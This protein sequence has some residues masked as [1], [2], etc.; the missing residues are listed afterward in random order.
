MPTRQGDHEAQHHG[1]TQKKDFKDA[2]TFFVWRVRRFLGR[3]RERE[4]KKK[5]K[6][7]KKVR[8]HVGFY[9]KATWLNLPRGQMDQHQPHKRRKENTSQRVNVHPQGDRPWLWKKGTKDLAAALWSKSPFF[10]SF[11]SFLSFLF[12]FD[13]MRRVPF[14][15]H[16]TQSAFLNKKWHPLLPLGQ[17]LKL[18]LKLH[19]LEIQKTRGQFSIQVLWHICGER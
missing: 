14:S 15:L 3:R 7:E 2:L 18:L 8:G 4:R 17:L 13:W 10:S 16:F 9:R 11:L 1:T 5:E 19:A 6:I 12:C